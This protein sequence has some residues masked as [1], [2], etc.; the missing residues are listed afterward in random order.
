MSE[1]E[2]IMP[3]ENKQK[4]YLRNYTDEG[5]EKQKI[6]L[7]TIRKKAMEKKRE[8][9]EITLKAKLMKL[10]PKLELAKQYDEYVNQ[11]NK[12]PEPEPKVLYVQ[13]PVKEKKKKIIYKE[14]E[15]EEEEE[16]DEQR[17]YVKTTKPKPKPKPKETLDQTLYKSSTEQLH[18]RA[19]EERI[20][21]NLTGW[22][23]ALMPRE[24]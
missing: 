13:K 24:Y 1:Q 16:E 22:H 9:K 12:Q 5:R 8:L 7:E 18:L 21:H 6:H 3:D 2:I 11:K 23:S 19:V 14:V 4:K 20:R 10:E 17:V 15:E